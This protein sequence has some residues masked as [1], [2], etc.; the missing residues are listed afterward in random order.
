MTIHNI[1]TVCD[2]IILRC[3]ELNIPL[4]LLKLQKLLYYC[5]AWSL[6]FGRGPL[7]EGQFQAWI[8]GPVSRRIYDRFYS[9][10]MYGLIDLSD[11]RSMGNTLT[12]DDMQLISSVLSAYGHMTGDQLEYLT[13]TEGPWQEARKDVAPNERSEKLISNDTMASYYGARLHNR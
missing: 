11:I 9:K 8:H 10:R 7:F 4:D 12:D 6:A 1:D 3:S 13:H 2:H 5:Q